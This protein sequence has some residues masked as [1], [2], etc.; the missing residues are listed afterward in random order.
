MTCAE[1]A[2]L[3]EDDRAV[4]VQQDLLFQMGA[5]GLCQHHHLEI[6]TLAREVGDGVAT[7]T[8]DRPDSM[9]GL[10]IATKE[11]LLDAVHRTRPRYLL[12]GH[13][14]QPLVDRLTIGRTQCVNVGHFRAS[15][16]PYV[17]QW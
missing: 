4:V 11:A 15:G 8:L 7:I 1:W 13:V 6:L 17:L 2:R 5:D 10:D 16:T 12:F 14:H 9:N 3:L